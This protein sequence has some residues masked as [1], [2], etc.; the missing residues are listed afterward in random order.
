MNY[1]HR[2]TQYASSPPLFFPNI[3][4]GQFVRRLNRFLTECSL[5]NK[6]IHAHLP[7]PG[8]L[9]EL[10]FP[11]RPVYLV[12]NSTP[13][14]RSTPYTLVAVERHGVPILLH[15]QMANNVVQYL[16]EAGVI[17]GWENV[18]I[19]KREIAIGNSRFDFYL[20]NSNR[21]TLL[22]V[23][24]CSL[25]GKQIAMFPDAITKRG[26]KH[27]SELSNHAHDGLRC[28]VIFLVHCP[29]VQYF[30]PDFHTDIEFARYFL[31]FK[32]TL[33]YKAITVTW[34]KNL[35]LEPKIHELTIPWKLLEKEIKDS[36]S[37]F[38]LL[39]IPQDIHTQI[40][41][42]GHLFFPRGFYIYV[43]SAKQNLSKRIERHLRQKKKCFWHIDFLRRYADFCK[44]IPVRSSDFLEHHMADAL[45]KIA[46]WEVL[47][48]GSSDC[49]CSSHLFGMHN[50]P[51]H[52]SRF[53][54]LLQYFRIDRLEEYLPESHIVSD[55][56]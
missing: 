14:G 15:T 31:D 17:S 37:Y 11:N 4:Q 38:L 55:S 43:G 20:Q 35:C 39:H 6:I 41:H 49:H 2:K 56:N 5:G 12:K 9:W 24:S 28:G 25:F 44:A 48:F 27:L 45:C 32:D 23:K 54:E 46:D 3:Q 10:L 18:R 22:E 36:G 52:S 21:K 7:N 51:L 47:K 30:L 19:I 13:S 1:S 33:F 40:G 34:D 29:H 26:T 8:R 53:I 50:N 42:L 16:I